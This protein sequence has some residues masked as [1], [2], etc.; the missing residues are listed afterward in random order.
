MDPAELFQQFTQHPPDLELSYPLLW[1]AQADLCLVGYGLTI[2][3]TSDKWTG[4]KADYI[5]EHETAPVYWLVE[6]IA[7]YPPAPV[8]P[9][10]P[11]PLALIG[12]RF[13]HCIEIEWIDAKTG[14]RKRIDFSLFPKFPWL[15]IHP[16]N[17]ALVV[18]FP[19]LILPP[20]IVIGPDL[21]T[22]AHGI[23]G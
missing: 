12:R 11:A 19:G 20:W 13:T 3:Y 10:P 16:N 18:V 9:P 8:A 5:H 23:E 21:T 22:T 1:P 7:G 2:S 6:K 14:E 4:E 15:A 17:N